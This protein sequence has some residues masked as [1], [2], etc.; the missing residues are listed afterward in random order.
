MNNVTVDPEMK[1]RVMSA[2]SA[3]IKEQAEGSA[4]VTEI[5][6]P[7]SSETTTDSGKVT[8]KKADRTK[9]TVISSIAA[10]IVVIAGVIF[11]FN[12]MNKTSHMRSEN[13]IAAD[14]AA[15]GAVDG[16]YE[17]AA[18]DTNAE[19]GELKVN[20]EISSAVGGEGVDRNFDSTDDAHYAAS[21]AQTEVKDVAEDTTVGFEETEGDGAEYS[22]GVGDDRIDRIGRAL[23]FD[24]AGNGSGVFSDNI[25]TELFFGADG[26]K[27]LLLTGPEGIDLVSA[28]SPSVK[29]AGDTLTTPAGTE[30]TLYHIEYGN[31][32]DPADGSIPTEVNAAFFARDGKTYLLVFSDIQS[33]DV[34]LGVVD[35]V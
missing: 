18:E 4:I 13:T 3:A 33:T 22:E 7:D 12:S 21:T 29:N 17:A 30:V 1:S 31:V 9:I 2:V 35:A 26:Q 15:A 27:V 14:I 34:I 19:D 24:L 8:R 16:G 5:H 6:K 25:T 28:F 20:D 23:P 11:I 10:A 32:I